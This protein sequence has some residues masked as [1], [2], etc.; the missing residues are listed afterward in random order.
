VGFAF[1]GTAERR[2]NQT[3]KRNAD[4]GVRI[5]KFRRAFTSTNK[6]TDLFTAEGAEDRRANQKPCGLVSSAVLCVL[7]GERS[8]FFVLLIPLG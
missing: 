6:T 8:L 1:S 5:L 4:D 7:C 3:A 2:E